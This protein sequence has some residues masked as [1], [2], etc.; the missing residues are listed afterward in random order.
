MRDLLDRHPATIGYLASGLIFICLMYGLLFDIRGDN[1]AACGRANARAL[2][3]NT[4][5]PVFEDLI[6]NQKVILH[7][8]GREAKPV[9]QH[10]S[11]VT[12]TDCEEAFPPPWP[13]SYF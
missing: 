11:T 13:W 6:S 2:E 1:L 8:I 10:V 9:P 7:H 12:L 5:V 4:R 3:V